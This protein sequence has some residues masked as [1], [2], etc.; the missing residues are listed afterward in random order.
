MY[1]D[2]EMPEGNEFREIPKNKWHDKKYVEEWIDK[3]K[4]RRDRKIKDAR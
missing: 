4:E 1:G 3:A 2:E